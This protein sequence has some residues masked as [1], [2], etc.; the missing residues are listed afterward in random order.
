MA[1][2]LKSAPGLWMFLIYVHPI[3]M[4]QPP[5]PNKAYYI[6]KNL[7]YVQW[8]VMTNGCYFVMHIKTLQV[9]S[10]LLD[11]DQRSTQE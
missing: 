6:F 7:G 9:Y 3:V 1:V 8:F 4:N 2:R 5:P 11:D 10:G